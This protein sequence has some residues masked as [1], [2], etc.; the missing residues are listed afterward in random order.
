MALALRGVINVR[1]AEATAAQAFS[2][3][4]RIACVRFSQA[5]RIAARTCCDAV[6]PR[7]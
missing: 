2:A 4:T 6:D 5:I 7:A 1:M 3:I